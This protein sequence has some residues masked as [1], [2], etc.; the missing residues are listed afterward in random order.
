[1][2]LL[3]LLKFLYSILI[4]FVVYLDWI[5]FQQLQHFLAQFVFWGSLNFGE[6][7]IVVVS[8]LEQEQEQVSESE[9]VYGQALLVQMLEAAVSFQL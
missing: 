2:I 6:I 4:G 7:V 3:H 8:A 5:D 1:M 9:P